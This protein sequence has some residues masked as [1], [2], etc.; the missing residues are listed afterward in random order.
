M[1]VSLSGAVFTP[2]EPG[3]Y[4]VLH[5]WVVIWL[6]YN[7]LTS[8]IAFVHHLD[9][10]IPGVHFHPLISRVLAVVYVGCAVF[11]S[12]YGFKTIVWFMWKDSICIVI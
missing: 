7:Q 4:T 12:G 9:V 11:I 2:P 6:G 3:R 8:L 5:P 10:K 1:T